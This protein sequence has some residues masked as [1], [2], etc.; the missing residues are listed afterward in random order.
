[1]AKTVS[2]KGKKMPEN[3]LVKTALNKAMALCARQEYSSGDIQS[4]L[5]SWGLNNSEAKSVISTLIKEDFINDKRYAWAFVRDKYRHNKWGKVKIA[6][7]L[8]AKNIS[9]ELISSALA[10][11]DDDQYRQM[12]RDTLD[13]HRKFI[14]AKNEYDLKGKLLRFGL[15][16]GFESHILYDIL[17]DLEE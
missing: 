3:S 16:K 11:L 5:E 15:S 13:S 12:V 8:K 1:M 6:A 9:S 14:K 2:L 4:K 7:H 10:S 17:N